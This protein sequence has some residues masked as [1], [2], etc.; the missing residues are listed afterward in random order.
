MARF[1][2]LV[3]SN[4]TDRYGIPRATGMTILNVDEISTIDDAT[5]DLTDELHDGSKIPAGV[6][7]GITLTLNNGTTHTLMLG[8]FHNP[9]EADNEINRFTIWLT[10]APLFI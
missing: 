4:H 7:P 5:V 1:E 6:Y 10:G 3:V 2:Q 8:H 9:D